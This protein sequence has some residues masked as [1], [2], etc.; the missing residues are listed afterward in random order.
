MLHGF[1]Q[2][3][4]MWRHVATELPHTNK[5]IVPDLRGYGDSDKPG[6]T[7]PETYSKRTMAADVVAVAQALGHDRFAS[8][9]TIAGRSSPSAPASTTRRS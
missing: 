5:V 3:R 2:T 7:G 6:T 4:V 9:G 8:S 1:P